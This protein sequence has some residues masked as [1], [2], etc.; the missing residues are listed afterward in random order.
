MS[1]SQIEWPMGLLHWLTRRS[2]VPMMTY[3]VGYMLPCTKI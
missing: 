1:V 2:H 3:T